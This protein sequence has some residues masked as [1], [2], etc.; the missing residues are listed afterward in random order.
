MSESRIFRGEEF[1]RRKPDTLGA[2]E[3]TQGT[4][5]GSKT[6]EG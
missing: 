2:W 6:K 4:K 3:D 5:R 1:A